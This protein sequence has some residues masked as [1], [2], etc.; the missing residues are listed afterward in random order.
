MSMEN[1]PPCVT[2]K[3]WSPYYKQ[4]ISGWCTQHQIVAESDH[5][6]ERHKPVIT[7]KVITSIP[8]KEAV[9]AALYFAKFK[10]SNLSEYC[11]ASDKMEGEV[12]E[13]DELRGH[14]QLAAAARILAEEVERLRGELNNN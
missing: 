13:Q 4:T 11:W 7:S 8:I 12:T 2:C 3:F 1:P 6:C 5:W 9:Q 10:E 14:A